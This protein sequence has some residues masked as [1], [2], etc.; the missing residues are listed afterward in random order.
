MKRN[1]FTTPKQQQYN[2]SYYETINLSKEEDKNILKKLQSSHDTMQWKKVNVANLLK[3]NIIEDFIKNNMLCAGYKPSEKTLSKIIISDEIRSDF[4]FLDYDNKDGKHLSYDEAKRTLEASEYNYIL[5]TSKSHSVEKHKLHILLPTLRALESNEEHRAYARHISQKLFADNEPDAKVMNSVSK[6]FSPC[7]DTVRIDYYFDGNDLD[8][9]LSTN[10]KNA[11]KKMS[12]MNKD[13]GSVSS[14]LDKDALDSYGKFI[15]NTY[16]LIVS[17]TS[18]TKALRYFRDEKDKTAMVFSNLGN[19]KYPDNLIFDNNTKSNGK[20]RE[21][22]TLFTY[23]DYKESICAN[24]M[25]I[26]TQKRLQRGIENFLEDDSNLKGY[27]DTNEGL[28]K[29]TAIVDLAMTNDFIIAAHTN[30]KL[31]ELEVQLKRKGVK[32]NRIKNIEHV[33]EEGN[34]S[35]LISA[36]KKY[37]KTPDLWG[38]NGISFFDFL[39]GVFD[40]DRYEMYSLMKLYKEN[41]D[42]LKTNRITIL[43]MAKLK[44]L[45]TQGIKLNRPVI[46][47]EFNK[48][49]WYKYTTERQF[50]KQKPTASRKKTWGESIPTNND[51]FYFYYQPNFIDLLK[52]AKVLIL[53]TETYLLQNI[54]YG[55]EYEE[56]TYDYD[57]NGMCL[58]KV[59]E[60]KTSLKDFTR[61]EDFNTY[62]SA[63]NN[64]KFKLKDDN[65]FY[66]LLSSTKKEILPK[67]HEHL[68]S[69]EHTPL[70]ISN[71]IK[72]ENVKSHLAVKGLN[73]L[74]NESSVII[75]TM[76]PEV[77][78]KTHLVNCI[79]KYDSKY[80]DEIYEKH[81]E[82]KFFILNDV[83]RKSKK[84][85]DKWKNICDVCEPHIQQVLMESEVSQSIGRNSGF[86]DN[87]KQTI[88]ILPLLMN[89]TNRKAKD[90]RTNY[91]S[92]NVHIRKFDI[93]TCK[94]NKI[95]LQ[96][97][98]T[99]DLDYLYSLV[100]RSLKFDIKLSQMKNK[101]EQEV[102][103]LISRVQ[104]NKQIQDLNKISV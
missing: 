62:L 10:D 1:D 67:I 47:D 43:T 45:L 25:R 33:L 27:V 56:L 63:L 101:T 7:H 68:N 73:S 84:E 5:T 61:I 98:Q 86:R 75:G 58:Y 76:S 57:E 69:T 60:G 85:P 24:E 74:A 78:V 18:D 13:D 55:Q 52:D 104:Y 39:D 23:N 11:L 59:G 81:E 28:G 46:F 29:S 8:L 40:D 6:F 54:L 21:F 12:K 31:D 36:Y 30:A 72:G 22:K 102:R 44:I 48:N 77:V 71:S 2:L 17:D 35:D 88:V 41:N 37:I 79:T 96:D 99:D 87:G 19:P 92:E 103:Y 82:S 93:R 34:R 66:I 51:K 42:L 100:P 64:F 3:K 80:K 91:I 26:S 16:G 4:V 83:K 49:D 32:F 15:K 70:I 90:F 95:E 14:S 50:E 53:S 97:N 38:E 94:F 65:V 9:E 20:S 89:N